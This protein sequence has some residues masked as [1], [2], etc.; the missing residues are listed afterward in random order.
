MGPGHQNAF[1]SEY[2]HVIYHFVGN[3]MLIQN[4]IP[5]MGNKCT[6]EKLWAAA[7]RTSIYDGQ[8]LHSFGWG[9]FTDEMI[10]NAEKF[11]IRCF[12]PSNECTNFD[13]LRYELYHDKKFQFDLEKFPAHISRHTCGNMRLLSIKYC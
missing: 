2:G 13:D 6:G 12:S 7:L 1:F 11:L 10:A 9:E 5:M 4:H 3:F 8:L